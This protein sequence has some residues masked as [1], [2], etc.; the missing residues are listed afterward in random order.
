[1][2]LPHCTLPVNATLCHNISCSFF[3][4]DQNLT[5]NYVKQTLPHLEKSQIYDFDP[6]FMFFSGDKLIKFIAHEASDRDPVVQRDLLRSL[7]Q[8]FHTSLHNTGT[9]H[10]P[11]TWYQEYLMICY[12][13][14]DIILRIGKLFEF[15]TRCK[16]WHCKAYLFVMNNNAP[17][18]PNNFQSSQKGVK[19]VPVQCGLG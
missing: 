12:L 2:P 13:P 5:A 1:M 17:S 7:S 19:L 9:L 3:E 6:M 11:G 16:V 18:I 15:Y 14:L 8:C 4:G 10:K